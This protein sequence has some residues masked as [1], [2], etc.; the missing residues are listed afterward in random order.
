MI[1]EKKLQEY[2]NEL[3]ENEKQIR[4]LVLKSYNDIALGKG[5]EYNDFFD[6]LESRYRDEKA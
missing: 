6:K 1:P 5:Q 4:K 3:N 2:Q